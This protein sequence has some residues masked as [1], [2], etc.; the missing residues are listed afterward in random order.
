MKKL[1]LDVTCINSNFDEAPDH[2]IVT[3]TESDI[4][5]I[6]DLSAKIKDL[7]VY[8]MEYFNSSGEYCSSM[9]IDNVII[10]AD[11]DILDITENMIIQANDNTSRMELNQIEVH[12]EYF[13]FKAV[14]KHYGDSELCRTDK[15]KISELE[16]T[17]VINTISY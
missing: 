9:T 7:D 4:K 2:L 15:V 13:K 14:P 6:K 8:S 10:S 11:I 1:L 5:K 17:N 12:A 3:L 16:N